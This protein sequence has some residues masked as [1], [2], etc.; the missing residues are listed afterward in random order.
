MNRALA[1]SLAIVFLVSS[2]GCARSVE[3]SVEEELE[4]QEE[5]SET[6]A[7]DGAGSSGVAAP[8]IRLAITPLQH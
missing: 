3:D 2:V 5:T 4:T 1:C 8:G 7:V 6:S